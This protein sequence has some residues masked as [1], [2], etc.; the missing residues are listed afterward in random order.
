MNWGQGEVV[1]Q[2]PRRREALPQLPPY[3]PPRAV[4]SAVLVVQ[5][6]VLPLLLVPTQMVLLLPASVSMR[7]PTS[8]GAG[9]GLG[10]R[11]ARPQPLWA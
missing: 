5:Q 3:L 4:A 2:A 6:A 11:P 10:Q 7:G 1:G 9:G 8:R